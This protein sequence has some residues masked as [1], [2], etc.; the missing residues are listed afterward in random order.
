[1]RHE[2]TVRGVPYT[3]GILDEEDNPLDPTLLLF[4]RDEEEAFITVHLNPQ[5]ECHDDWHLVLEDE[6]PDAPVLRRGRPDLLELEEDPD[7]PDDGKVL[8]AG[9][10][11]D[12]E[13]GEEADP[14]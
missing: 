2:F 7:A 8:I 14:Q 1:M 10:L 9:V 3:L 13:T 12:A 5:A 4:R 11:Y 6:D